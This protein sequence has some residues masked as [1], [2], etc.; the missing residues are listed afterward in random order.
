[1]KTA[2]EINELLELAKHQLTRAS[3]IERD[4]PR[5]NAAGALYSARATVRTALEA[6]EEL[7][8]PVR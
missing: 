2:P 3:R 5:G 4:L 7:I 8:P 1:M 6:L